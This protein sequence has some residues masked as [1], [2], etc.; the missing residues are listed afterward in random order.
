MHCGEDTAA[1][2]SR[3]EVQVLVH[4]GHVFSMFFFV[5]LFVLL[6]VFPCFLKLLGKM[7]AGRGV[8]NGV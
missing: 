7:L 8:E 6:T 5:F 1:S 3:W 2:L 4:C